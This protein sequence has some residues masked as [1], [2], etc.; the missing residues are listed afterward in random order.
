MDWK[1]LNLFTD[2]EHQPFVWNGGQPA[3]LLVHGF[4]GT[5]A[6]I[7]PLAQLLHAD[8]WTTRGLLLPGFGAD[9]TTLFTREWTEWVDAAAAAMT[10]LARKHR[11]LLLVGFSMGGAVALNAL[12][13]LDA[14]PDHAGLVLLAPFWRL[15]TWPQRA[16]FTLLKPVLRGVRPLRKADFSDPRLRKGLGNFMPELDL[17]DTAV[18]EL[19]REFRVPAQ[20]FEN[21]LGIGKAARR[22]AAQAK[23]P[24]LV[25]QGIA[26]PLV[27]REDTRRLL[28]TLPGPVTYREVAGTHDLLKPEEESWDAVAKAVVGY[29]RAFVVNYKG[30]TQRIME[31]G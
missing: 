27:K 15:G 22:A 12:A 23:L 19:L 1:E 11:P 18:Q 3:A 21:L 14:I 24:T 2:E 17:D 20:V 26:D 6:E 8:G 10:D 25:V 31:N 29:G 30:G 7:R 28:Q 9:I 4:P 5:P 16:L 13:K